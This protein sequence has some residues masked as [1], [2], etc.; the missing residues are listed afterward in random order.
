MKLP[1]DFIQYKDHGEHMKELLQVKSYDPKIVEQ[2][3]QSCEEFVNGINNPDC[4]LELLYRSGEKLA[5][6]IC[7]TKQDL[8]QTVREVK[9]Q[10]Y[11]GIDEL[12]G[13]YFSALAN[14]I[15][16]T[17]RDTITLEPKQLLTGLGAYLREGTL[18]VGGDVHEYLGFAMS[19][20]AIVTRGSAGEM[21][22]EAMEN[23]KI[24]VHGKI[25]SI[26]MVCK[27]K[28][29]QGGNLVWPNEKEIF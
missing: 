7:Y 20:G 22:G 27:G 13:L 11:L 9:I 15:I 14:N 19:G 21:V 5:E 24:I 2:L 18:I 17:P 16:E 28:I 6:T 26:S 29:Y 8:E 25:D 23:G 3:T 4:P 12:L 10:K 1:K